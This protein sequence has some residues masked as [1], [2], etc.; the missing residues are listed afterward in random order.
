MEFH[1]S[2]GEPQA[3]GAGVSV[4]SAENNLSY[5]TSGNKKNLSAAILKTILNQPRI[6]PKSDE[7][8]N[9]SCAAAEI[10]KIVTSFSS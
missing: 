1:W 4:G 6:R 8:K 5:S 7:A 10:S 3:A 9:V 2:F